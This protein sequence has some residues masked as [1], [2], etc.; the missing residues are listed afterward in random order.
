[1]PQEQRN[2]PFTI[3]KHLIYSAWKEVRENRGSAG[4]DKVSIKEYGETLGT[5]LYKLWNRMSSGSYFPPPVKLVEIPKKGGGKRPL[6]IPTV[7]DRIA[8]SA[9]VLCI[10]ERL[11]REFHENSY[12]YRPKRSAHDAITVARQRCWRYDWVLD[13]DISKFFDT[14][15]QDK[16]MMAVKRH[17]KERWILLYIER[18]LKVPYETVQ[19]ERIERK[20]GV[21]QGS[22]IGPVLANLYLHYVFDKWMSIHYSHIPFER[23]AD[24]TICHCRTKAEAE[25]MQIV[26]KNRLSLCKLKLNEEKT[27]IVY[28][29]DS[30][31]R[32]EH[33]NVSFD[34]LGYTFQPRATR[35]SKTKVNFTGFLPAISQKSKKH[36]H[37][38]IRG[39]SLKSMKKMPELAIQME[40]SARGWINYYGK[41]YK[42]KMEKVLQALNHAIARW[43][44][45]RYKRFKGS[46]KRAWLWVIKC[47][48]ENPKLF[49]HWS[50]GVTPY[51]FK[52]KLVKIRRAE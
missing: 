40:A 52:L 1:M 16:L 51:Y 30:G 25:E 32:G 35:N 11:D 27:K 19:G 15:D 3:P 18:W 23:Y 49:Y 31:R 33:E 38:T 9:V 47:Y 28:C 22:I 10:T 39:W 37:E 6:G 41:F 20:M 7:E 2:K 48:K 43:A 21:P 13:M 50:K 46:I 24:D 26:I 8:Q 44:R 4:I 45:R 12:A 29:K 42:S 17:I 36:I 14:I 34:F 5:N